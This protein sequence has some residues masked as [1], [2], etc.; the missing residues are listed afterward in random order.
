MFKFLFGLV[1]T[2]FV[3]P[4]FIMCLVVPGEQRGGVDM[5]PFLFIF[6]ILFEVIGLY[7]LISGLRKII[8]DRK[9]KN[10]GIKCYGI[11]SDIQTTGSYVNGNP[12]YKAILDFVNPETNQLETIEE[13]IG[14]DYNE[15][16]ID[17]YVLCKYYQ[18]DINL[19]N[20]VSENEIPGDIKKYLVTSQQVPNYSNLE[21]SADREYVTIDG[22][23]YKKIH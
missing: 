12:E 10:H 14:F 3:T 5:N 20:L 1:W 18:G 7:M 6:F 8:K 11:V 13:I 15:Y 21:F 19:E 16:P 9:T 4:I 23:Q 17:S 2:A 22:V